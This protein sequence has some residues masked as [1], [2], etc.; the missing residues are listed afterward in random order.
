MAVTKLSNSGIKTGVLKYDSMLAGNSAYMPPS[1]DS[2]A[3]TTVSSPTTTVTFSSIPTIYST[4]QLRIT[5]KFNDNANFGGA[6]Y[7]RMNSDNGVNYTNQYYSIYADG[8][9][10]ST[11][12]VTQDEIFVGTMPLS[13]NQFTNLF[14]L[15][16]INITNVNS[17][18]QY[19]TVQFDSGWGS[20]VAN[21]GERFLGMGLHATTSATTAISLR[22][23]NN[24]AVGSIISL[25]GLKAS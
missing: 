15:A 4:L 7:M 6:Y 12:A 17:T 14:G 10:T 5:G 23:P 13:G 22:T 21:Q 25:Y 24:W 11:K 8:N 1:Y 16:V 20:D 19:K 18:T 3:S 2:I 9:Q